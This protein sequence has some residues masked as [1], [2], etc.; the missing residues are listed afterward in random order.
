MQEYTS[1]TIPNEIREE[2]LEEKVRRMN[3]ELLQEIEWRRNA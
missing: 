3:Q 1:D 2:Q